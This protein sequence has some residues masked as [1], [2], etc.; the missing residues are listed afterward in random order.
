MKRDEERR[1]TLPWTW[2][3]LPG[4]GCFLSC[5]AGLWWCKKLAEMQRSVRILVSLA[6]IQPEALHTAFPPTHLLPS[7]LPPLQGKVTQAGTW[8]GYRPELKET[9]F[10][11]RV[12]V[13]DRCRHSERPQPFGMFPLKPP[14]TERNQIRFI[15]GLFYPLIV[16]TLQWT[17]P[18][19]IDYTQVK[20]GGGREIQS[21][22]WSPISTRWSQV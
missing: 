6:L 8:L 18:A 7:D 13:M 12:N 22:W 15:S 14:W 19:G 5:S 21:V 3:S 20:A 2:C 4:G 16:G 10:V 1:F 9:L 17:L 11:I